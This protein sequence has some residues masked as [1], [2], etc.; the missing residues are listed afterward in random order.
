[1]GACHLQSQ[2]CQS[3]HVAAAAITDLGRAPVECKRQ[4]SRLCVYVCEGAAGYGV[5]D[6]LREVRLRT[7]KR[8]DL[9]EFH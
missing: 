6:E 3:V 1:M 2:V 5:H 7:P 8:A 9:H 4:N